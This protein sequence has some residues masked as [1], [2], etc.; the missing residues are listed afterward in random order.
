MIKTMPPTGLNVIVVR[1]NRNIQIRRLIKKTRLKKKEL[2]KRIY[3]QMPLRHKV[4]LADFVIDNNGTINKTKK[5]VDEISN[6][7]DIF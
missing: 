7:L 1:I 5:Q 4:A 3:A 2:M 6:I